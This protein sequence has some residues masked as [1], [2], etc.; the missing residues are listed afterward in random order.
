MGWERTNN[1][2]DMKKIILLILLGLSCMTGYAQSGELYFSLTPI[3]E[4][5]YKNHIDG[6]YMEKGTSN[7]PLYKGEGIFYHL[8]SRAKNMNIAFIHVNYNKAE[9][10]RRNMKQEWNDEMEIKTVDSQA[11]ENQTVY[12][13]DAFFKTYSR[14]H[15]IDWFESL[16]IRNKKIYFF[17]RRDI[18]TGKIT[19]VQVKL[20]DYG[21]GY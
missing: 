9:L 10:A 8:E 7:D 4:P 12:D 19:L 16:D 2:Y 14:E 18:S 1:I 3:E 11:I 20:I 13:L 6:I 21:R 17:D 5:N 15:F